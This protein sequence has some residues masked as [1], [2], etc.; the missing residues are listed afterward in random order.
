LD[1]AAKQKARGEIDEFLLPAG[2]RDFPFV[3]LPGTVLRKQARPRLGIGMH[4]LKTSLA[5]REMQ[6]SPRYSPRR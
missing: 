4:S 2:E 3:L 5:P 1:Q 6:P